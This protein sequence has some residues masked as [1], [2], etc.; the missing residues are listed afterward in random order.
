MK[1]YG[2]KRQDYDPDW[3]INCSKHGKHTHK[4]RQSARRTDKR[5]Y[6]SRVRD[7][8]GL[9]LRDDKWERLLQVNP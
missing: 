1:A 4:F 9:A 7:A 2:V 8:I 5:A 6:R 3:S